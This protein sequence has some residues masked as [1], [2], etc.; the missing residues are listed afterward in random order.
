MERGENPKE[1]PNVPTKPGGNQ[2]K[3]LLDIN[4]KAFFLRFIFSVRI[5]NSL[6]SSVEEQQQKL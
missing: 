4:L 6:Q 2:G 3:G 1:N 5:N